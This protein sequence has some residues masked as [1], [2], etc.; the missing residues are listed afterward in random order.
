MISCATLFVIDRHVT[1]FVIN[2]KNLALYSFDVLEDS[3]P[4]SL[5]SRSLMKN[6][7]VLWSWTDCYTCFSALWCHL[8]WHNLCLM[9]FIVALDITRKCILLHFD[10]HQHILFTYLSSYILSCIYHYL[11]YNRVCRSFNSA[12]QLLYINISAMRSLLCIKNHAIFFYVFLTL[13]NLLL[14]TFTYLD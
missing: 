11:I 12:P 13:G 7:S 10:R 6:T 1:L 8:S 3:K 5:R 2:P 9:S 4:L 14:I